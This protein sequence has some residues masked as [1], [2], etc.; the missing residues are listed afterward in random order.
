MKEFLAKIQA[1]LLKFWQNLTASQRIILVGIIVFVVI[2]FFLLMNWI[3]QP[4]YMVL[5]SNLDQ[6][7]AGEVVAKIKEANIKYRLTKD[8]STIEVPAKDVYDLRL[9]LAKDGL[10][11]KT[12]TGY[13]LFDK[14]KLGMS[15]FMQKISYRRA[16]EGELMRTIQSMHEIEQARVHIVIPEPTLFEEDKK[17]TTASILLKLRPSAN[18]TKEQIRGIAHI[19]SGSVEGLKPE[20]VN[21]VDYYGN[22]LSDQS[23]KDTFVGLSASQLELKKKVDDYFV[24][25]IQTLFDNVLGPNNSYVRADAELDFKK[26]EKTSEIYDPDNPVV[27][28]EDTQSETSASANN[29]PNSSERT[30]TNYEINKTVEH[31]LDSIGNVKR[32]SV[33]IF[34]DGTYK[35]I[36]DEKG[37]VTGK[38]YVPR[39]QDEIDRLT[40]IAKNVVGFDDQRKD[41]IVVQNIAFD[42]SQFENARED[43]K[44]LEKKQFIMSVLHKVGIGIV[45][46][47]FLLYLRSFVRRFVKTTTAPKPELKP[48][49]GE[50]L[51]PTSE[52]QIEE[53]EPIK[54]DLSVE[55][56]Q[57]KE[58]AGRIRNFTQKEPAEVAR[59]IRTWMEEE[60]RLV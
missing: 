56:K 51:L 55:K 41:Q 20:N 59:L 11:H 45:V 18:L 44:E 4:Q 19:V 3:R 35:E 42:R 7:N 2:G 1:D 60:N 6:E 49:A 10:P 38:E 32:L 24:T 58:Q 27:R 39:T 37:N 25:K 43:L 28:S 26:V 57:V 34:V 13:E 22:I 54:E 40:Q 21:I 31:V 30:T 47:L 33:A 15:D 8:G 52:V 9:Q 48:V 29:T 50:I 17:E 36:K 14:N 23:E 12:E 5:Y 16:I 46:L 53:L